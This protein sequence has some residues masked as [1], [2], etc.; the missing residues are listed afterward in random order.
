MAYRVVW[1]DSVAD[2]LDQIAAYIE[3]FDPR[4]ADRV[5]QRLVALS[6]SL[7]DFPHRGR[8]ADNDA[9]ELSTVPP[10][11]LRYRVLVR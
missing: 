2:Q 1:P 6:E 10:Y 4:A 8:P 5:V 7:A 11:I 9:R 3:V